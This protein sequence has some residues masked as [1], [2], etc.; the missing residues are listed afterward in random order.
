[1][2]RDPPLSDSFIIPYRL[3]V[4][5]ATSSYTG[6]DGAT[7]CS[8]DSPSTKDSTPGG[9]AESLAPARECHIV[10][11]FLEFMNRLTEQCGGTN[12][13]LYSWSKT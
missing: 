4:L 11:G 5:G 10:S 3:L 13:V 6:G 8:T 12:Q 9:R 2:N 7:S 1:M